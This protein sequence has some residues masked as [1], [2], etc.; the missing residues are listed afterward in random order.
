MYIYKKQFHS[1]AYFVALI[2]MAANLPLS[3]FGMSFM[4]FTL[5]GLWLWA[6][7]SFE[8]AF[9]FFI[10]NKFLAGLGS[11][12]L[13]IARLSYTNVVEK[14]KLFFRN[15]A[16]MVL[17]SLFLLHLIGLLYTSDFAYAF[18]DLRTKL[19]LLAF[20]VILATMEPLSQR[21]FSIIMLF[22]A[23]AV[24]IGTFVSTYILV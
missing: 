13:Y 1:D 23:A 16:A 18:K 9:S 7:F 8:T 15:K 19:P 17:V 3:R 21:K 12:V 6:G 2:L 14:F 20:P 11:F 5:L 10:R 24:L 22:H 4:E